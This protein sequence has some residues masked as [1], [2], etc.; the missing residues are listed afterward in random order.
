MQS[1]LSGAICTQEKVK[2]CI[3]WNVIKNNE[4]RIMTMLCLDYCDSIENIFLDY[5]FKLYLS[6]IASEFFWTSHKET[7]MY[8]LFF[9]SFT[10]FS[11]D[12]WSKQSKT[13]KFSCFL[14][15]L[16]ILLP[17][18]IIKF[19]LYRFVKIDYFLFK[20]FFYNTFYFYF[21]FVKL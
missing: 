18:S 5:R 8:K 1:R 14:Q 13:F 3:S 16:K 20:I 7:L 12:Y 6:C 17:T 9:F 15:I 21:I 11:L 4:N 2:Q 10:S 19:L